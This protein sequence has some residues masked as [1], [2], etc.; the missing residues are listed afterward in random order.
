MGFYLGV[1]GVVHGFYK[2]VLPRILSG[3]KKG[4]KWFKKMC[5]NQV[6]YGCQA[7]SKKAFKGFYLFYAGPEIVPRIWS[8][9][10]VKQVVSGPKK[11]S[12]CP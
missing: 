9:T 1:N 7:G 11:D 8:Q 4:S 10:G 3:P 2:W 12:V 6:L 5:A